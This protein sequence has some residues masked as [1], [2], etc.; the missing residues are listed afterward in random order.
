MKIHIFGAQ[1]FHT[2]KMKLMVCFSQFYECAQ[3]N[4][5]SKILNAFIN[6]FCLPLQKPVWCSRYC[7]QDTGW[8]IQCSV[9]GRGKRFFLLKKK[10]KSGPAEPHPAPF[11]QGAAHRPGC[12]IY[13]SPLFRAEVTNKWRFTSNPPYV[14]L[15]TP[16][17]VFNY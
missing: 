2:D 4:I 6:I 16:L 14:L 12:E 9:P 8:I 13:Q 3:I 11:F 17:Y 10:K 15:R 7:D 1:L 5:Y